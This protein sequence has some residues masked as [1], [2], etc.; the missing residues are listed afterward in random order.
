[1]SQN[2][3]DM[4]ERG[5][6]KVGNFTLVL[7]RYLDKLDEHNSEGKQ[8]KEEHKA[9]KGGGKGKKKKGGKKSK[10]KKR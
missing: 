5:A 4:A 2:E 7:P 3:W 6:F 8:S 1:M 10:K 9:A